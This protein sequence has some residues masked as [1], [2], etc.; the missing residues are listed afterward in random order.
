MMCE[1][2]PNI[3]LNEIPFQILQKW[4]LTILLFF[5]HSLLIVNKTL[6]LQLMRFFISYFFTAASVVL[7]LLHIRFCPIFVIGTN[8]VYVQYMT[9]VQIM[10]IGVEAEGMK[11]EL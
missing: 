6:C 4:L 2:C 11:A 1:F 10:P 7:C 5:V 8:I 9:Y 3:S